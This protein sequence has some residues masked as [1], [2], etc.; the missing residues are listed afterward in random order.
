VELTMA[1]DWQAVQAVATTALVV[2]SCGAIAYAGLQ[3]RNEREYRSVA[4]L[5]KH[6]S[7]FLEAG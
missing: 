4:N 6:L 3:L 5:E 7:F 2:T 1:V